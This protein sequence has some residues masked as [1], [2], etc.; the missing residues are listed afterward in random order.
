MSASS[1]SSVSAL[2]GCARCAGAAVGRFSVSRSGSGRLAFVFP[3]AVWA[4]RFAS[5]LSGWSWVSLVAS[6]RC[7]GSVV[8]V[9]L[10]GVFPPS[11]APAVALAG[12]A[13]AGPPV[14]A[15]P[16]APPASRLAFALRGLGGVP[17]SS[18][19]LGF[20]WRFSGPGLVVRLA[21]ARRAC[22]L[23]GRWGSVSRPLSFGG[24]WLLY[25]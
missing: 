18:G 19:Q 9:A 14:V 17:F 7:R 5:V 10:W 13:A 2:G 22:R 23:F 1:F 24:P 11:P 16:G 20:V 21:A 15:G 6:V 3:S 4:S 12:P 8:V 25:V